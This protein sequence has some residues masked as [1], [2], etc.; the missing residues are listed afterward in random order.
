MWGGGG[1]GARRRRAAGGGA[2]GGRGRCRCVGAARGITQRGRAGG[3]LIEVE[4]EAPAGE[5]GGEDVGVGEGALGKPDGVDCGE[6]DGCRCYGSGGERSCELIEAEEGGGADHA[7]EGAGSADD[8]AGE[9]P[10]GGEEDG[11]E[12]GGGV[13]GGGLGDGGAGADED[14]A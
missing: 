6:K 5:G 2:G 14:P 7:D 3:E 9:V 12:R 11:G 8:V 13:G 10:P 1:G 4:G